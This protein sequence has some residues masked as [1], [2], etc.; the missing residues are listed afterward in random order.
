VITRGGWWDV[1][2]CCCFFCLPRST[3]ST[4]FPP[5]IFCRPTQQTSFVYLSVSISTCKTE[6]V[7]L[8]ALLLVR[9][10]IQA[11]ECFFFFFLLHTQYLGQRTTCMP[12]R[13]PV[14]TA[15]VPMSARLS[16]SSCTCAACSSS[17]LLP[18]LT[19]FSFPTSSCN[20]RSCKRS[21]VPPCRSASCTS[22]GRSNHGCRLSATILSSRALKNLAISSSSSSPTL[23]LFSATK[24][25]YQQSPSG[26]R[27]LQ[28]DHKLEGSGQSNRRESDR[29]ER[30]R[31]TDRQT[32]RERERKWLGFWGFWGRNVGCG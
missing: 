18:M 8:D 25:Q 31:E 26:S 4:F 10:E 22:G 32:E 5:G 28:G 23:I 1:I 17:G 15:G 27:K 24:H 19:E 13:I 2:C 29:R 11:K 6:N 3:C 12:R 20:S 14:S 7:W 21:C 16:S 30:E 9:V